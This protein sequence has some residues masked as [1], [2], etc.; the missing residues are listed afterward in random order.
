MVEWNE[1]QMKYDNKADSLWKK[2]D[3]FLAM[4]PNLEITVTLTS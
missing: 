4:N 2:N 3:G 1:D